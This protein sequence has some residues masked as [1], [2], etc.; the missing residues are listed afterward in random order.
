MPVAVVAREIKTPAA[1]AVL[2]ALA[3]AAQAVHRR[4]QPAAFLAQLTPAAVVG[5]LLAPAQARLAPA[6]PASSSS[7]TPYPFNLS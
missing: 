6:A 7:S 2:V 5:G 3:A 4:D 1:Q